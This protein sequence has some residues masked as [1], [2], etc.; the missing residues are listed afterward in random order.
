MLMGGVI[1]YISELVLDNEIAKQDENIYFL[2]NNLCWDSHHGHR[3]DVCIDQQVMCDLFDATDANWPHERLLLL[4]SIVTLHLNLIIPILFLY[5]LF[6]WLDL[7]LPSLL[8]LPGLLCLLCCRCCQHNLFYLLSH[9]LFDF[10][11]ILL[12]SVIGLVASLHLCAS[13]INLVSEFY[14]R[15]YVRLVYI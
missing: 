6:I 4:L 13:I 11:N 14:I 3:L 15:D 2:N 12:Q 10:I 1:F 5:N 9:S 7:S 8:L